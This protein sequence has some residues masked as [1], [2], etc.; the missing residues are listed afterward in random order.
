MVLILSG[1]R[2]LIIIMEQEEG[3]EHE[4]A[5]IFPLLPVW[6]NEF[7]YLEIASSKLVAF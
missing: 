2:A 3:R 7:N 4:V 6:N 1:I 5:A